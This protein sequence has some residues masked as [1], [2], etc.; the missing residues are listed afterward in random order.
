VRGR[1]AS[2][3]RWRDDE[4]SPPLAGGRATPL[5]PRNLNQAQG[6][7]DARNKVNIGVVA[8][9]AIGPKDS[10]TIF[11][12]ASGCFYRRL[13]HLAIAAHLSAMFS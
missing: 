12:S 1:L 8:Y 13:S 11:R 9:S 4:W 10:A 7:K 6:F 5:L 3:R 2:A